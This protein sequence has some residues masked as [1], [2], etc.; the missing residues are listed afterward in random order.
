V[1]EEIARIGTAVVFV[2]ETE[3]VSGDCCLVSCVDFV[4]WLVTLMFDSLEVFLASDVNEDVAKE[5]TIT[6]SQKSDE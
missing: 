6:F 4:S 2:L 1:T 3:V 5:K